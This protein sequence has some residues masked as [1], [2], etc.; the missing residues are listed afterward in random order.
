MGCSSIVNCCIL[1][2]FHLLTITDQQIGTLLYRDIQYAF[3]DFLDKILRDC[4]LNPAVG[5]IPLKWENPVY[6]DQQPNFTDFAAPGVILS[7][8]MIHLHIGPQK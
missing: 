1:I 2:I 7:N 6:G 4:E 8:K 5:R 3:F